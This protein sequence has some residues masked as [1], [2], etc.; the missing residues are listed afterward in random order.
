M[1]PRAELLALVERLSDAQAAAALRLLG[2]AL[3]EP[4]PAPARRT[5]LPARRNGFTQHAHVGGTSIFFTTGEYPGCALGEVFFEIHKEGAPFR[6]MFNALAISLSIGFQH[7]VPL[8]AYVASLE[9]LRFEPAG[10][11]QGHDEITFATSIVDYLA[12][13]LGLA[14]LG[15]ERLDS[16]LR[17]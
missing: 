13:A 14:Y 7:G 8:E 3:V 16:E 17:R 6:G 12:R 1:T 9:G 4:V 2:G 10:E 5:L 11:V 15:D